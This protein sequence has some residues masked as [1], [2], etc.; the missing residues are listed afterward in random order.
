MNKKYFKWFL[1]FY[2]KQIVDEINGEPNVIIMLH[3]PNEL[4]PDFMERNDDILSIEYFE[5][6]RNIKNEDLNSILSEMCQKADELGMTLYLDTKP[7]KNPTPQN[8]YDNNGF[9]PFQNEY[10][11]RKPQSWKK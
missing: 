6:V 8:I 10:F 1:G 2:K 7:K 5:G 11:I 4:S 9:I 3:A